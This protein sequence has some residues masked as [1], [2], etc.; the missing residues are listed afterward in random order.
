MEL[1]S[2]EYFIRKNIEK[3]VKS[4]ESNENIYFAYLEFCET[5]NFTPVSKTK[6]GRELNL[7]NIGISHKPMRNRVY[8]RGRQGVRLK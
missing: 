7:L 1:N 5:H 3:D 8:I 2:V 6:L 4:F